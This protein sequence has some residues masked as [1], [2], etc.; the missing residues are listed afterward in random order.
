MLI[1]QK[2]VQGLS[3]LTAFKKGSKIRVGVRGFSIDDAMKMGFGEDL[4]AGHV[5]LPANNGSAS[6]FNSIGNFI[7]L[8]DKEKETVSMMR[9]WT[10]KQWSGRGT[11]I[12]VTTSIVVQRKRYQRELIAPSSVEFTIVDIDGNLVIMSPEFI[13]DEDDNNIIV[14]INVLLEVFGICEI[15]S[16][17]IK[18]FMPKKLIRLNWDVL[19]KGKY[20]WAEQKQRIEKFLN[21]AK[22][23]NRIVVEKRHEKINEYET[24]F[25]AI[26]QGGFAG[27][28]IHGFNKKNLF[29]LESVAVNNATYVIRGNWE[30]LSQMTKAEILKN[31]LH[32]CRVIHNAKWYENIESILKD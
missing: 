1:N 31:D 10:H 28:I 17:D 12:D 30:K 4:S 22:G 29:I 8:K 2:R 24:D 7:L 6:K 27:Y 16:N 3:K 18:S 11:T 5:I 21:K 13:L 14:S 20:P 19:P 23:T 26:G 15:F 32:E 9:E 25:T